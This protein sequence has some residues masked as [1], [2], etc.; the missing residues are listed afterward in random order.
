[1]LKVS[2]D[3]STIR[4]AVGKEKASGQRTRRERRFTPKRARAQQA[5][6]SNSSS[7]PIH[8]PGKLEIRKGDK[9]AKGSD[10][11]VLPLGTRGLTPLPSCPLVPFSNFW[12]FEVPA[13]EV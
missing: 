13:Q 2:M 12:L 3:A 11:L 5:R 4:K 1:M 8:S 10:R 7:A 9:G 6:S